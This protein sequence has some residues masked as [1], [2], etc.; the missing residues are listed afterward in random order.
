MIK[1]LHPETEHYARLKLTVKEYSPVRQLP[2]VLLLQA[3]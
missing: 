1:Q 2:Q 3:F